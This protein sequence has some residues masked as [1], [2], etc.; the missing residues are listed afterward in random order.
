MPNDDLVSLKFYPAYC[1]PLSPT[2]NTWVKLTVARVHNLRERP[3]F[4]GQNIYFYLNHPV[5][6]VRLVGV[7]VAIDIYPTRWILVLDDGSGSTLEITCSRPTPTRKEGEKP[8]PLDTSAA[9]SNSTQSEGLSATGRSID[10]S[11]VDVGTVVKVKGGIGIFRDDKQLL[12]ERISTIGTTSGEASAWAENNAFY[13][14]VLQSPWVVSK[15]DEES[16][17]EKAEGLDRRER[18]KE[19]RKRHRK[20]NPTAQRVRNGLKE[21]H[22]PYSEQKEMQD[23][24]AEAAQEK[25]QKRKIQL[26]ED[27]KL[28]EREFKKMEMQREAAKLLVKVSLKKGTKSNGNSVTANEDKSLRY[29]EH[30][31]K[32]TR[33]EQAMMKRVEDRRIRELEFQRLR[34]QEEL[35][36]GLSS[37]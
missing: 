19:K 36:N 15:E 26:V 4:E 16:A 1:F 8:L 14:D 28:R 7:I 32:M 29:E 10:L 9:L 6:W 13:S 20:A 5:K 11:L 30:K 17:R 34:C 25:T 27:K 22:S 3:G 21:V 35:I 33:K 12:L 24:K 18:F 23:S 31:S 37:N 2:L